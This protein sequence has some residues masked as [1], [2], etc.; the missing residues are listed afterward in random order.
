MGSDVSSLRY[1]LPKW[2]KSGYGILMHT[3]ETAIGFGANHKAQFR[4]HCIEFY[5]KYGWTVFADAFPEVPRST[6]YRWRKKY[7]DSGKKLNSLVSQSTKP[8]NTRQMYVP[9]SVLGF[10]KSVREQHPHLSKYKL[11]P[12]LDEF[13]EQ[14]RLP[15]YS[16]SWIGKVLNRH[17]LFFSSRKP[18]PKQR[19]RSR[20]GYTIRRTPRPD[21]IE[22]G[23]LQLDGITVYWEGR[24]LV[25]LTCMELKTRTAWAKLVPTLNSQHAKAFLLKTIDSLAY[26]VHTIHTDNGSEFHAYFDQAVVDLNLLHLWSPPRSPKI[27]SHIE[28]FNG[29]IQREFI[30][31]NLIDAVI[32][33]KQFNQELDDWLEWYNTKRPHH[34]LG[35]HTPQQALLNLQKGGQSLKCP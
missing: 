17:Q 4:L 10:L 21:K 12:F 26:P 13:C 5:E 33:R 23:Y 30:S 35:L 24:K 15:E 27:H 28:R 16:V 1:R 2:G 34:G 9:G 20:S 6:L 11:K 32:D 8:K 31:Y 14:Q 25:F 18:K 3:L 29:T 19:K 7:L 22:I